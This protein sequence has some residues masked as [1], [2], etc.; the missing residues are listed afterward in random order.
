M[1]TQASAERFCEDI[2]QVASTR[3]RDEYPYLKD[4]ALEHML[5]VAMSSLNI[6]IRKQ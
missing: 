5:D 6:N 2:R 3:L 1:A 4:D